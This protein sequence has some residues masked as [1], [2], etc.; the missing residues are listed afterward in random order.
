MD[1]RIQQSVVAN[2]SSRPTPVE[3]GPFVIGLDPGTASPSVNYATP[4]PGAPITVVD[5]AALVAAFREADR[6][7]R[8]EFVTSCAPTLEA[9]L[10]AAGFTVEA[11]HD[12]LVC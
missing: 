12:Y 2:L 7:P 3:I 11:R 1:A 5:V 10:L 9:L 4:R 6:K 8:L